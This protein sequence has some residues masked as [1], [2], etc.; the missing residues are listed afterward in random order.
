MRE[1][2]QTNRINILP[3]PANSP[4]LNPIENVWGYM[5]KKIYDSNFR[6]QNRESLVQKIMEQWEN[7]DQYNFP[8]LISSMAKRCQLVINNNGYSIKY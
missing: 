4:D 7:L 5:T 6:P 2:I 8:N 1:W 3:W